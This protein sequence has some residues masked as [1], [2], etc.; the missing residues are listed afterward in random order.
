MNGVMTDGACPQRCRSRSCPAMMH[1]R[2]HRSNSQ[3]C[4]TDETMHMPAV[5]PL[6]CRPT[7]LQYSLLPSLKASS[8]I[9]AAWVTA[10]HAAKANVNRRWSASR[11]PP[12]QHPASSPQAAPETSTRHVA[13]FRPVVRRG[14]T[15]LL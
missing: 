10:A 1:D 15:C 12:V 3:L 6:S 11:K 5:Q 13:I 8:A 4:G 9:F 14:S 2:C 7:R